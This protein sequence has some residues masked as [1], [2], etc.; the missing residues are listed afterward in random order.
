M[1]ETNVA[2]QTSSNDLTWLLDG[3][4]DRVT[5][6]DTVLVVSTDGLPTKTCM[7]LVAADAEHLS[8]ITSGTYSLMSGLDSHYTGSGHVRQIVAQLGTRM[9]FVTEAAQGSLLA[10]VAHLGSDAGQIGHEMLLLANQVR[11]HLENKPRAEGTAG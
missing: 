11:T 10:V 5:G 1:N 7:G 4:K 2:G 3:F 9:F 8:A 6:I